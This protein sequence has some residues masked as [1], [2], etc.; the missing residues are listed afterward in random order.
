MPAPWLAP[1]AKLAL[2]LYGFA[3]CNGMFLLHSAPVNHAGNRGEHT[4][5]CTRIL[6]RGPVQEQAWPICR[7]ERCV[8]EIRNTAQ[9]KL[10]GL[11]FT[12]GI[13]LVIKLFE[14]TRCGTTATVSAMQPPHAWHNKDPHARP[15]PTQSD[16]ALCAVP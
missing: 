9:R 13:F 14:S 16:W 5:F 15:N 7:H 2:F 8:T 3:L 6:T 12:A 4:R 10:R 1:V 11:P